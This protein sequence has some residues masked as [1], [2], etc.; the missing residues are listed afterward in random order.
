MTRVLACA[1]AATGVLGVSI[2]L[3]VALSLACRVMLVFIPEEQTP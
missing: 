3:S 1:V 2:V